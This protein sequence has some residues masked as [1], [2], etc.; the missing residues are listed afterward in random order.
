ML[1]YLQ[2]DHARGPGWR[3]ASD[4]RAQ[5]TGRGC[6][7]AGEKGFHGRAGAPR[8]DG[9]LR[10]SR[11]GDEEHHAQKRGQETLRFSVVDQKVVMELDGER[12]RW[13]RKRKSARRSPRWRRR[14]KRNRFRSPESRPPRRRRPLRPSPRR[15]RTD[16]VRQAARKNPVLDC[17][18]SLGR[19]SVGGTLQRVGRRQRETRMGPCSRQSGGIHQLARHEVRAHPPGRISD[20][21]PG[22][23]QNGQ[24]GG[25]A[26]AHRAAHQTVLPG[27]V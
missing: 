3:F 22:R 15:R 5:G 9:R 1:P 21:S 26:A 8:V 23:I 7:M 13:S 12:S 10:Q 14:T 20:G 18:R 2:P 24:G 16:A 11:A 19:S 25:K 4:G 6:D 17:A 27:G